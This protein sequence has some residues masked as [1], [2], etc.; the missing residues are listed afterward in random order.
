MPVQPADSGT[1]H[2]GAEVARDRS[3]RRRGRSG[4]QPRLAQEDAQ[5]AAQP[6]SVLH[7]AGAPAGRSVVTR[8]SSSNGSTTTSSITVVCAITVTLHSDAS[9]G[10]TAAYR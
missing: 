1:W 2:R 4:D 8:R 9:P 6:S 3:E 7:G 10:R 5:D